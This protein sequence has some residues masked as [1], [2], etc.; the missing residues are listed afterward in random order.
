[1]PQEQKTN[2][3][4]MCFKQGLHWTVL[5]ICPCSCTS[6]L[7]SSWI[8]RLDSSLNL[9]DFPVFTISSYDWF[10]G[11]LVHDLS[12]TFWILSILSSFFKIT[13]CGIPSILRSTLNSGSFFSTSDSVHRI[14]FLTPSS[15]GLSVGI[16]CSSF[17]TSFL[18]PE[19][20]LSDMPCCCCC[21]D[22]HALLSTIFGARRG[23]ESL[24]YKVLSP[25]WEI[26][27]DIQSAGTMSFPLTVIVYFSWHGEVIAGFFFVWIVSEWVEKCEEDGPSSCAFSSSSDE[28]S[29]QDWS[30]IISA[31]SMNQEFFPCVWTWAFLYSHFARNCRL[32]WNL[33][34]SSCVF[35]GFFILRFWTL[36]STADSLSDCNFL[37]AF[38]MVSLNTMSS[39]SLK[40]I[41][42]NLRALSSSV[43]SIAHSCLCLF[44]KFGLYFRPHILRSGSCLN[45]C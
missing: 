27:L 11:Y 21:C 41:P 1:M 45:F 30:H 10:E 8:V 4:R 42:L 20:A 36:Q 44:T 9:L 18:M 29:S 19:D 5:D 22:C 43:F 38:F 14:S 17:C 31:S 39:R 6:M 33:Q 3:S 34:L 35:Y 23:V 24:A 15:S 2:P 12:T 16:S 32:H 25:I 13:S 28:S 7:P 26:T 37:R 40:Q